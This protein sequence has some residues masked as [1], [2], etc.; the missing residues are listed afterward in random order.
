MGPLFLCYNSKK[1]YITHFCR[2]GELTIGFIQYY[3]GTTEPA[4]DEDR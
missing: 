2:K 4:V 3:D 1:E